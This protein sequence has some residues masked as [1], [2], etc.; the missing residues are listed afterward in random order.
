[1][2]EP[3]LAQ[4]LVTSVFVEYFPTIFTALA[5]SS[6][7]NS[8]ESHPRNS[9]TKARFR[10][11]WFFKDGISHSFTSPT[12]PSMPQ[13]PNS[14]SDKFPDQILPT[15]PLD[16]VVKSSFVRT[17]FLRIKYREG[18]I[19]VQAKNTQGQHRVPF[20]VSHLNIEQV[21]P[22][23]PSLILHTWHKLHDFG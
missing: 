16:H 1:M 19:G 20:A 2:L 13:R 9:M 8:M 6:L 12:P 17:P 18:N 14:A 11:S 10:T 15:I 21:V 3:Q 4:L 7:K 22:P 23:V 5:S